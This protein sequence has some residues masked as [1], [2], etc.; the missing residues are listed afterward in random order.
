M[1]DGK[2]ALRV[3]LADACTDIVMALDAEGR[4][5]NRMLGRR[6]TIQRSPALGALARHAREDLSSAYLNSHLL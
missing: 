4:F 5:G 1:P 3:D 2:V 6:G